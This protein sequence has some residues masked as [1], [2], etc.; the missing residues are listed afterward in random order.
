MRLG[1][2]FTYYKSTHF[3]TVVYIIQQVPWDALQ[4]HQRVLELLDQQEKLKLDLT[5]AKN[6]LLIQPDS[7]SFDCTF[8]ACFSMPM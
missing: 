1:L 7:W 6:I 2:R 3:T 8:F 4:R 5:I